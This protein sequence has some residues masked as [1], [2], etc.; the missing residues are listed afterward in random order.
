MRIL[1]LAPFLPSLDVGHAGGVVLWRMIQG[2]SARHELSLISFVS[3]ERERHRI[4]ALT[5]LGISVQT[6]LHANSSVVSDFSLRA[7]ERVYSFLFS[8]L[9]Y[10]VWRLRAR[11]MFD[12]VAQALKEKSFDIVQVEFTAMAQYVDVLVAHPRTIFR[13]HDLAFVHYERRVQTVDVLWRKLYHHAQ[14]QRMR[15]YELFACRRFRKV[16]VPS[17]QAKAELLARLPDL[18]VQVVPFGITLPGTSA[19][20]EHPVGKRVL[21]VGAMGRP[22]NVEAVIYFYQQIWP[23]IRADEPDAELWIVGSDPPP[24]VRQ[25]AQLDSNVRVTGFVD[26]LQSCYIQASVFVAPLLVGGGVVTKILDAMAM[27]KAV[28]TTSVGNEGIGA[29]PERDLLIADAP[30]AFA[31]C[32]IEMLRDPVRRRQIGQNGYR[33]VQAHYSWPGINERLERVYADLVD[34]AVE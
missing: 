31:Q 8:R 22:L 4:D 10:G 7:G 21:F 19:S 28:V 27:S 30:E 24:H 5:E 15:R 33:F 11:A 20:I 18:D 2:L 25:L 1:I 29:T 34:P 13:A 16:I 26:D 14:W 23:R 3:D 17:L 9:P 6:V 32:V 12:V